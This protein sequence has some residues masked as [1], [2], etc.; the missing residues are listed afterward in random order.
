MDGILIKNVHK[1]YTTQNKATF[2]ALSDINLN[3]YPGEF[4]SLIGR[5]GSG[6]S[7]LGKIILGL[8]KPST[9]KI[10]IDDENIED[11]KKRNSKLIYK[12][13]QAVFQDAGGSLNPKLSVYHN[14]EESLVN[15]TKLN[16]VQ[17]KER[18]L[19]LMSLV[20]MNKELLKTETRQ[21]SGGEQR[22]L[23]L[24]RA[25]TVHPKYIILDEVISGLDFISK[26]AVEKLLLSYRKK[27]SCGYLFIT[28]DRSS[29]YRLS[30]RIII[31]ENGKITRQGVA[32]HVQ[33]NK[34]V[35]GG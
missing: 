16:L 12:K 2:E 18:I 21:L 28:H 19:E 31:M 24:L 5:S 4:V 13:M 9:G 33:K 26:N 15:L 10:M 25:L 29:A 14:V 35:I 1:Y 7:T 34:T 30:D 27:Y 22:R 23:S 32:S 17:R 6:K 20:G 8:E 11:L 3:I